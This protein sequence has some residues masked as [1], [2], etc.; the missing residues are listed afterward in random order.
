MYATNRR[1]VRMVKMALAIAFALTAVGDSGTLRAVAAAPDD[2]VPVASSRS[3]TE[4]QRLALTDLVY[5]GGFRLP[6]ESANGDSFSFGGKPMAFNPTGPS[7]FI[8]S[9][10]GRLAEVT[11][12][13]LVN[14]S[15][16]NALPFAK[17]LQGF[18]DPTE[19]KLTQVAA[20]GGAGLS[21]LLVRANQLFG[22]ASIY[23]DANNSQRLSHF[24]RSLRLAESSFQGW[25]Q[26]WDTGKTGFVA[27]FMAL[28][29]D[30]W[31]SRLGG[32]AL[33]G[34]CCIP[35][36]SRTSWG[37]AAFAFDLAQVG[38][39]KIEASPLVYYDSAHPTLGAWDESSESYGIATGMGGVVVVAR[40]R[41][42]LYFGR[43]GIGPACYGTGTP[44]ESLH[45]KPVGDGSKYCYDPT[46]AGKGTHAYPYRY[47]VWAYDLEDFAAV[48]T[49]KRKP[50]DVKPYGIW[51]L[52][53]PIREEGVNIGGVTYD[54]S[55]NRIYV[56][57]MG[58]DRDGL[59]YRP[60]VH[61]FRVR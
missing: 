13:D 11:I 35:I 37:P 28:I 53:F 33:T 27:G 19:G 15:D 57:Q 14:S 4:L 16:V 18:A 2:Q 39:S 17:F 58:A 20:D 10:K 54:P 61:A 49:G 38:R 44:T 8:S 5:E 41:S 26:V 30:E 46:N 24:S 47:Q 60:L 51:A 21:G 55:T 48:R 43:N 56:V 45:E 12:P 31:Q 29:P 32:T 22:T 34:Q 23:Y 59:E 9:H 1:Q 50:W 42:A 52:D 7:L 36:V 40:T 3:T 6:R 25:S